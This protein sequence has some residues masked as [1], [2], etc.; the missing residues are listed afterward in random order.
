MFKRQCKNAEE[1]VEVLENFVAKLTGGTSS[2]DSGTDHTESRT[3][4][5]AN[6]PAVDKLDDAFAD[7]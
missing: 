3:G 5:A 7:L 4:K 1:L 6:N 2:G